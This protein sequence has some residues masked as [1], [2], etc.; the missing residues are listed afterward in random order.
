MLHVKPDALEYNWATQFLEE[1]NTGTLP[2][3]FGEAQNLRQ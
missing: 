3:K 2:A 1:I